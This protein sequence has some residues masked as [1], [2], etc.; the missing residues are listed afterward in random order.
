MPD[1]QVQLKPFQDAPDNQWQDLQ[2]MFNGQWLPDEDPSLIGPENYTI[3]QNLRYT[4]LSLEGVGG[5]VKYNTAA[6]STYTKIRAGKQLRK[7]DNLTY[8]S[9]ILVQ[10]ID[11]SNQGRVFRNRTAVDSEG[12]FISSKNAT[13]K[14]GAF[15]VNGNYYFADSQT[16]L[17]GRFS[18]A[19][20]GSIAYCNG[21]ESMIY[22]G[23]EQRIAAAFV[24]D[25]PDEAAATLIKDRTKNASTSTTTGVVTIDDTNY[26]L[27]CSTNP[28]QG[29]K[30]YIDDPNAEG[31]ST[32]VMKYWDGSAWQDI[33][34][35]YDG[36]SDGTDSMAQT[37][38]I[39]FDHTYSDAKPRHYQELFLYQYY[40]Q[41]SAGT[42]DIY[43]ITLDMGFQPI[44]DVWDGVY[45]QPIQFQK[46]DADW[47]DYTLYVNEPSTDL[48]APIGAEIGTMG[49]GS[50]PTTATDDHVEIM[51][52]EPQAGIKFT[53]V[54]GKVNSAASTMAVYYWTGSAWSAL[55][56]VDG[57]DATP[58]SATKTLNKTGLVHWESPANEEKLTKFGTTGYIYA[59]KFSAALTGSTSSDVVIDLITG[60]PAQLEVPPFAWSTIFNNRLMLGNFNAGGQ[61]NRLDFSVSSTNA[62]WNG[63]DSSMNGDQSLFFGGSEAIRGG[64]QLYNRFGASVYSMLLVYK[65]NEVYLVVG[66]SPEDFVIYPVSSIVGCPAPDT[67]ATAELGIDVAEGV[68]RNVAIWLSNSGPMMFDGATISKLQGIDSY[69]ERGTTSYLNWDLVSQARGWYDKIYK[70]YNLLLPSSSASSND[71]WLV[72]DLRRKKWYTKDTGTSETPQ[73]VFNCIDT[74][75]EAYTLA[76]ADNGRVYKLEQGTDWDGAG[77]TQKLKTGDFWPSKNIWDQTTIRKFKLICHKLAETD[78]YVTINYYNNGS[79]SAGAGVI[80]QDADADAGINVSFT[81]TTGVSWAS[82]SS[83]TVAL[84]LGL[85]RLIQYIQDLNYTNWSHSFEFSITTDSTV[86]G[87]QPLLWGIQFR[88]ERK[89]NTATASFN[90]SAANEGVTWQGGSATWQGGEVE[91]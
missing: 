4:N 31:S 79:E 68:S 19:P 50:F 35:S 54:A 21:Q 37:G 20:L 8:P 46:L 55:T 1:R 43:Y 58:A 23:E 65:D 12:N 91:W 75:G 86:K 77:I 51:F 3:L 63:A 71:L 25:D 81:D 44:V 83:A 78:N 59:I 85:N 89:D 24:T 6:L 2:W 15:D 9:E 84:D 52:D 47:A 26:L 13:T 27:I 38:K 42:A 87:W 76:G 17:R 7:S 69:F 29:L 10:A 57:T 72:F 73:S 41:L 90:E 49:A 61:E 28:I 34:N 48:S 64:V 82:P 32:L 70:E 18:D 11:S 74:T 22:Q 40:L 56:I 36:T 39:M 30:V 53:M 16:G 14:D 67:I 80:H 88:V 33:A 45:R 62:V 5:Y 66:E 60:I